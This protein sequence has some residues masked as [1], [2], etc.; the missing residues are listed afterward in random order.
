MRNAS[1]GVGTGPQNITPK[2]AAPTPV[3]PAA[4][5]P[6]VPTPSPSVSSRTGSAAAPSG[7]GTPA[8]SDDLLRRVAEAK[9]RVA[10][11]QTKLAVKDNPY[12]VSFL[13]YARSPLRSGH[14]QYPKTA[15]KRA[16]RL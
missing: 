8:T 1:F 3:K 6:T 14:S 9:R 7:P 15:R 2:L 10:E 12:M 13:M 16:A 4:A 5:I 11:A